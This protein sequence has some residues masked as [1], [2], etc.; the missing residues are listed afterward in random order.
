MDRQ[1]K[2]KQKQ[3]KDKL[4][5][6]EEE[7]PGK[8]DNEDNMSGFTR[9]DND[10]EED[11]FTVKRKDQNIDGEAHF[12]SDWDVNEPP[13]ATGSKQQ[14]PSENQSTHSEEVEGENPSEQQNNV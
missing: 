8:E 3:K 10:D 9:V 4:N 13:E 14:G 6:A 7:R 2:V 12:D 11:V 5:K 1:N